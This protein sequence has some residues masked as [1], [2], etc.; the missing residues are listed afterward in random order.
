MKKYLL[1]L[2]VGVVVFGGATA[3]AASLTVTNTSLG[4]GNATVSTCNSSATVTYNTTATTNTKTYVV[5][6]TPVAS[7]ATCATLSYKVTLLGANN[8]SLGEATGSLNSSGGATPD[9]SSQNIAASDVLG[10]A[11]VITG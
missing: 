8:A 6:T 11:V 4:A 5:T 3:F 7:A 2:G 1:P 10:V 9:F